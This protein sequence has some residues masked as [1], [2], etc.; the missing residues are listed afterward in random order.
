MEQK[1]EK[2]Y[3]SEPIEKIID[4]EQRIKRNKWCKK[5]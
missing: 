5:F 1:T 4:L 2:L 3:P